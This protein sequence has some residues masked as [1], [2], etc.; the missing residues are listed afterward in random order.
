[1]ATLIANDP[2][3]GALMKV[4]GKTVI[5]N[6]EIVGWMS[7][8]EKPRTLRSELPLSSRC[9]RYFVRSRRVIS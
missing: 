7:I 4:D 5:V 1:M 3:V 9:S 6:G 2:L 8:G